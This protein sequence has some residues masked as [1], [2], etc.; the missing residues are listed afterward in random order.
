MASK[1]FLKPFVTIPVAPVI[2][3]I[4]AH[5]T[6]SLLSPSLS[7]RHTVPPDSDINPTF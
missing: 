5:F 4:I 3:G 7:C 1:C 6:L 2:T